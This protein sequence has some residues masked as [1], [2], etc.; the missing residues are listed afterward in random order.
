MQLHGEIFKSTLASTLV[1]IIAFGVFRVDW[2]V[3]FNNRFL[4]LAWFITGTIY[5]IFFEYAYHSIVL[6]IKWRVPIL[7]QLFLGHLKHHY[8]F[9]GTSLTSREIYRHEGTVTKW[10]I[11]PVLF[12]IHFFVFI[13][14][15]SYS[16]SFPFFL[17]ITINFTFLYQ[18]MH[19]CTH[20]GDNALDRLIQK[21]PLWPIRVK[22][23]ED[24]FVH[25]QK[26]KKRHNFSPY[27]LGD[28][29]FGTYK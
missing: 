25:H 18:I 13:S 14:I 15:F 29:I 16:Y 7:K 4:S 26:P 20:L 17:G 5:Y 27:C 1:F 11:F 9:H 8:Y 3:F 2:N 22:Q 28:R 19:H 24:H 23:I 21:T 10:Y 12:S 6:H